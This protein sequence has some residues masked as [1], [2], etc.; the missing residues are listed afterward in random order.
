MSTFALFEDLPL[1]TRGEIA[2]RL[3][4][5][6]LFA[7]ALTSK[8]YHAAYY[9]LSLEQ[10]FQ[11]NLPDECVK[12]GNLRA[13]KWSFEK[14]YPFDHRTLLA[15]RRGCDNPEMLSFLGDLHA[16]QCRGKK[17]FPRSDWESEFY[18]WLVVGFLRHFL[19]ERA[20]ASITPSSTSLFSS[21]HVDPKYAVPF[22]SALRLFDTNFSNFRYQMKGNTVNSVDLKN[23][24]VLY[25]DPLTF[26]AERIMSH[27]DFLQMCTDLEKRVGFEDLLARSGIILSS[28]HSKTL[29]FIFNLAFCLPADTS[30][31]SYLT[32]YLF[33]PSGTDRFPGAARVV[34]QSLLRSV[35]DRECRRESNV[36]YVM[37]HWNPVIASL[38]NEPFAWANRTARLLLKLSAD[39]LRHLD[40]CDLLAKKGV[41]VAFKC[42]LALKT[43]SV[44]PLESYGED[45]KLVIESTFRFNQNASSWLD[46]WDTI[47]WMNDVRVVDFLLELGIRLPHVAVVAAYA[48]YSYQAYIYGESFPRGFE[49][50][51]EHIADN[52][53]PY[54]HQD[55]RTVETSG[56]LSEVLHRHSMQACDYLATVFRRSSPRLVKTMTNIVWEGLKED[57]AAGRLYLQRNKLESIEYV[58]RCMLLSGAASL[59]DLLL[60]LQ[61]SV[62]KEQSLTHCRDEYSYKILLQIANG[63][64]GVDKA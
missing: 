40:S 4:P 41:E 24:Y 29:P 63:L 26:M 17:M 28:G 61:E 7:F 8:R 47:V 57:I 44:A 23:F 12:A 31:P 60:R 25:D 36:R 30:T 46:F 42:A 50:F 14:G 43:C 37:E 59:E 34:F 27:F 49:A 45:K 39:L 52:I 6:A 55:S 64:I 22:E 15:V 20:R 58:L 62:K 33:S 38:A 56:V 13:L 35:N 11:L 10:R 21:S 54:T 53:E 2:A 3:D 9:F 1:E 16:S 51:L 18:F 48:A 32:E 5:F 19:K